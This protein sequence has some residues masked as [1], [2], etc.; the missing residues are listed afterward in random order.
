MV[1]PSR[2]LAYFYV[3]ASQWTRVAL[4]T[5]QLIQRSTWIPWCSSFSQLFHVWGISTSWSLSPLQ[6][7]SQIHPKSKVGRETH[8]RA[9]VAATTRTQVKKRAH[10][11]SATS[12]QLKQVLKSQTQRI[13]CVFV[14][15]RRLRMFNGGLVCCSMRLGVP[16]IA[17]RQ[18]GA[19]GAPFGRQF[20]PSI[21][22]RTRQSGAP[23]D[24]NSARSPSLFGEDDHCSQGPLGTSD[25][26]VAHRKVRCGLV[27]VGSSHALPIDCAL[28]SLP[29]VGAGTAGLPDSPVHIEQSGEILAAVF[30]AIS[31]SSEFVNAPAWAPDSVG[32]TRRLVNSGCFS[33]TSFAPFWTC[34][35]WV[36]GT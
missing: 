16:F 25:S 31:E 3:V 35:N 26:L 17:L 14:E 32:C 22:G 29:I 1:W 12:L 11:H 8:T 6:D 23:P 36:S 27:A 19:V 30:L 34:L 18:L 5:F 20:L 9:R 4:N 2:T 33:W 13:G 28:I 21:R 7:W 15:S 24:M 10:K